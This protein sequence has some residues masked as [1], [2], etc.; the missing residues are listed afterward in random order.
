MIDLKEEYEKNMFRDLL[1]LDNTQIINNFIQRVRQ[2]K[3]Q[4]HNTLCTFTIHK[5]NEGLQ[6]YKIQ[7]EYTDINNNKFNL[8]CDRSIEPSEETI[9]LKYGSIIND[10]LRNKGYHGFIV[11]SLYN[12][13]QCELK[14]ELV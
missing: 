1:K 6:P 8:L 7:R 14:L 3:L 13:T 11:N 2:G 10:L 12:N 5:L 9:C 4:L